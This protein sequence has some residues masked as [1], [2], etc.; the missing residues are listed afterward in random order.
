MILTAQATLLTLLAFAR[1]GATENNVLSDSPNH[2]DHQSGLSRG[3]ANEKSVGGIERTH[4]F[5]EGTSESLRHAD[6]VKGL[7]AP[8]SQTHD[9]VFSIRLRNMD[10]LERILYDVSDPSSTNYGNHLTREDIVDLTSNVQS[11]KEVISYLEIAGASILSEDLAGGFISARGPVSVWE[12][13]LDTEFYSYSLKSGT[14]G[15][16]FKNSNTAT[17]FLR[18]ER[19]SV[20]H[21]L[22]AHIAWVLDTTDVPSSAKREMLRGRMAADKLTRKS[23]FSAA[24]LV[25]PGY[26]TPQKLNN[27]YNITDNSGHPLAIQA[28]L[29]GFGQSVS[30]EDLETFQRTLGLPIYPIAKFVGNSEYVRTAAYCRDIGFEICAEANLDTQYMIGMAATTTWHV[31]NDEGDFSKWLLKWVDVTPRPLVM[32]MSYNYLES[33]VT[34][35]EKDLFDRAAM[36]LGTLGV[37]IVIASGDDGAAMQ[38]AR[39]DPSQCAYRASF[40]NTSPYVISVGATQVWILSSDILSHGSARHSRDIKSPPLIQTGCGQRLT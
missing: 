26:I 10:E 8:S 12:S 9:L 11:C 27:A 30:T 19:Y 7:R 15:S 5:R 6:I 29:Q 21:S 18:T 16:E 24:S 39:S 38:Y 37:T 25:E 17:S 35:S 34:S 36:M 14:N 40:P 23:R 28:A 31:Y 33:A 2:I 13:M 20:P 3:S 1:G 32:S 22:D 4:A